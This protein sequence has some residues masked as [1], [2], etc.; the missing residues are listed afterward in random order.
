[1]HLRIFNKLYFAFIIC[2]RVFNNLYYTFNKLYFTFIA[3]INANRK[4]LFCANHFNLTLVNTGGHVLTPDKY[5]PIVICTPDE[6]SV[7]ITI[8]ELT[9]IGYLIGKN[10]ALFVSSQTGILQ[11]R[12]TSLQQ[13]KNY[14]TST[15]R[16]FII[17]SDVWLQSTTDETIKYI[18]R[19]DDE[20]CSFVGGYLEP[21]GIVALQVKRGEQIT[22]EQ[23]KTIPDWSPVELAG[24]GFYYGDIP[25]DY[26]FKFDANIVTGG[27]FG[28]DF[29][30]FNDH[31]QF[32][33]KLAKGIKLAHMKYVP[34]VIR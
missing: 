30:F 17:D 20:H 29:N 22:Q 4:T 9:E 15:P 26:T 27:G 6:R 10:P 21:T 2:L 11:A 14:F 32:N 1:M 12:Q 34:L 31:P 18:K 7:A 8:K 19:A 24:L 23:Y 5:M 16:G 13:V 28:E 25:L 33:T 3:F